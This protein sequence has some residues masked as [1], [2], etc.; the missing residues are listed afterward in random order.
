M[1]EY[2]FLYFLAC[3]KGKFF[4]F[5]RPDVYA[6]TVVLNLGIPSTVW[7]TI[8]TCIAARVVFAKADVL[9]VLLLRGLS[10]IAH[11]VVKGLAVN[12]VDLKWRPSPIRIKPC[13]AVAEIVMAIDPDREIACNI[14][15]TSRTIGVCPSMPSASAIGE[16]KE[17]ARLRFVSK[18]FAQTLRGK[19]GSSH[20]ALL[21]LIGQR[22]AAIR[23]R[24][25]ASSFYERG[26]VW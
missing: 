16:P 7:K 10:Q 12:V 17:M 25:R 19:I 23:S 24:S 9:A 1:R 20:E 18:K 11:S 15:T 13:K 6:F 2:S 8:N 5:K 26:F 22:P 3:S 4:G 21:L 14:F